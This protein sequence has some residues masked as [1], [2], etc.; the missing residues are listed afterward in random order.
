[1][2]FL[3]SREIRRG[4]KFSTLI[5]C[6][7]IDRARLFAPDISVWLLTCRITSGS[8]SSAPTNFL[9][10]KDTIYFWINGVAHGELINQKV[11][12]HLILECPR[13]TGNKKSNH[14]RRCGSD[15]Y[16][17]INDQRLKSRRGHRSYKTHRMN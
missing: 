5:T 7:H 1:M 3:G 15:A 9:P 12:N 13:F 16:V 14:K 8:L 6:S 17:A 4:R 2:R 11:F 10:F